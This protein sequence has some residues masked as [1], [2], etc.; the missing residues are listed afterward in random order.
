MGL[1]CVH[2][3]GSFVCVMQISYIRCPPCDSVGK[4]ILCKHLIE[5]L[6]VRQQMLSEMFSSDSRSPAVR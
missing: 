3:V 4:E 1:L 6:V 2:G 5:S